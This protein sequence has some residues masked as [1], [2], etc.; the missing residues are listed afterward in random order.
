MRVLVAGNSQA[1]CLRLALAG[2]LAA[3]DPALDLEFLVVPGGTGPY[4]A[5]EDGRLAVTLKNERFPAYRFPPDAPDRPLADYDA[6]LVSA[7]GY[8]DG[9][10]AYENPVTAQGQL[11]EYG[12]K[13]MEPRR[14][15]LS[16][17]CYTEIVE[18][19][20]RS[21]R[22]FTF[23]RGLRAAFAG[24]VL[25]QPFPYPSD[26]LAEREDWSLRQSHEDFLGAHRFLCRARDDR[27]AALC[28][29]LDVELLPCPDPAW[30]ESCFTPRALMR[31][32]DC[33]H[34]EG[35]YGALVLRQVSQ[36]LHAGGA[37]PEGRIAL[38]AGP[39]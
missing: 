6:V 16:K 25:V 30:Q 28:R 4:L 36:A 31:D 39:V 21:Q 1:G 10:F 26:A 14:P 7:L 20:L 34:A 18:H 3:P 24:P 38:G 15:L 13:R 9:G 5:V 35:A 12:P 17:S 8:V 22:G 33:I 32:A 11:A 27:L 37:A 2:G 19:G 23:L 29:A